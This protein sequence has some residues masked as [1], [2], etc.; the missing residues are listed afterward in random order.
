MALFLIDGYNVL[1]ALLRAEGIPPPRDGLGWDHARERLIDRLASHMAGTRDRAVAVFD[2]RR[3]RLERRQTASPNV[4]VYFG[5]LS[6]S[7]DVIIE[8]VAYRVRQD[9]TVVVVSSDAVVQQT[10][11]APCQ[12]RFPV[13][14]QS[15][16]Q[17]VAEIYESARNIAREGRLGAAGF[18]RVEDRLSQEQL[19][20]LR[21]LRDLLEREGGGSGRPKE[22]A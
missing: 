1:H 6:R 16:E 13:V 20:K 10:V 5:S 7:A 22:G 4:E 8:R 2:S 11:F 15:S 14:R 3:A 17:F 21:Q 18:H 9:E 12:G 19:E